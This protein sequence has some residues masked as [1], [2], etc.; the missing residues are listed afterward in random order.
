M[1]TMGKIMIKEMKVGAPEHL[2]NR[3]QERWL[4]STRE[5]SS[6]APASR[7]ASHS[8]W[9]VNTLTAAKALHR[10]NKLSWTYCCRENKNVL[11]E[12][13]SVRHMNLKLDSKLLVQKMLLDNLIKQSWVGSTLGDRQKQTHFLFQGRN[14]NTSLMDIFKRAQGI[15]WFTF[16]KKRKT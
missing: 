6:E 15:T 7:A 4:G 12:T 5:M 1:R 14:F 3:W 16:F 8:G 2:N 11:W 13:I 9:R 10:G